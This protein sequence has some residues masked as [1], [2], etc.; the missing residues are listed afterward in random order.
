MKK[1]FLTLFLGLYAS[2]LAAQS[3]TPSL[4]LD[5]QRFNDKRLAQSEKVVY[6]LGAYALTNM[7]A[8]AALSQRATPTNKAF[9]QMNIGWNAVNAGIAALGYFQWRRESHQISPS[10]DVLEAHYNLKELFILNTALDAAYIM[11]GLY[12]I[13]K[14]KNTPK[15]ADRFKG[16]GRAVIY[17]GAFLLA[18]DIINYSITASRTKDLHILLKNNGLG[19]SFKF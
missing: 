18:F 19:L 6:V 12:L 17:N 1:R 16:F 8:S 13:E 10:I 4:G 7:A 9:H 14:S 3:P 11:G 15:N 2:V 5:W